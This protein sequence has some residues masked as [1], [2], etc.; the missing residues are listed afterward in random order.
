MPTATTT[1][2]VTLAQFD[3]DWKPGGG[4]K[5]R[6]EVTREG[7]PIADFA[8]LTFEDYRPSGGTPLRDATAAFIDT[9]APRVQ[10]GTVTIGLLLDRS[11]SMG[12]NE[13]SVI[14]GVNEFVEGMKGVEV[15]PEADGQVLAVIVTDGGENTSHEVGA[16]QI[17][18]LIGR[19]EAEGW[20]FIYLGA[21]Q[22]AWSEADNLGYSG[23]ASGQSVNYVASPQGL[24]S[25]MSSVTTDASE[26]LASNTAYKS[27]RAGSAKRSLAE[28]GTESA[29]SPPAPTPKSDP[30]SP[31]ASAA[32][33]IKRAREATDKG[34]DAA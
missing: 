19:R 26:F 4:Q 13:G 22:D 18:D 7:R 2:E 9:L 33:A 17:K 1:I 20:T 10:K 29:A 32:D 6:Y 3:S 34:G 27:R 30:A 11:G 23:G 12:G 25:A 15:D 31:Y 14:A 24:R 16:S 21:N 5:L 8:P 28:D